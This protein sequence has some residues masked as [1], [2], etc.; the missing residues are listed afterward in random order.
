MIKNISNLGVTL[1]K[2]E[3]QNIKGG[4]NDH[5]DTFCNFIFMCP[6]GQ[7]CRYANNTGTYGK[8]E[9]AK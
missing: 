5:P 4:N 1:N 9:Y 2:K 6:I 7:I 3:Q 8:C